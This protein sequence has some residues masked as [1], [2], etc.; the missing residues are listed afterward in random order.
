VFW[1]VYKVKDKHQ[2]DKVLI[3]KELFIQTLSFRKISD[4]SVYPRNKAFEKI[5]R[6]NQR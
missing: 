5:Y 2:L 1:V 3:I 6:K 4:L